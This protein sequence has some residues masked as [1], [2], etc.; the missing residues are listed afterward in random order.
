MR[1]RS[2]AVGLLCLFA[3][4]VLGAQ[5]QRPVFRAAAESLALDVV[6][7]DRDGRPIL[8]LTPQDL[9]GP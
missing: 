3:G 2:G 7:V 4:G 1:V 6:V 8:G 5:E 9:L